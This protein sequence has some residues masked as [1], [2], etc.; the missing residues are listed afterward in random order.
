[1]FS[2][3][4]DKAVRQINVV[5]KFIEHHKSIIDESSTVLDRASI[6]D[7]KIYTASSCVTRLYA[8][9][10]NYVE[11]LISDYLDYTSE[12]VRFRNLP[13]KLKSEYRLGISHILSRSDY[14]RYSHLNYENI[15]SWY[16]EALNNKKN[17]KFVTE[18]LT[19]HEQ[20][21]RLSVIENILQRIQLESIQPWLA[22]NNYIKE[23][24]PSGGSAYEQLNSELNNFI[25]TR[26][27]AAHGVFVNIEGLDILERYCDLIKAL[28]LALSSYLNKTLIENSKNKR[29]TKIGKVT[30]TFPRNSA[31]IVPTKK[32]VSIQKECQL[33]FIGEYFCYSQTLESIQINSENIDGITTISS[34][35][36]IGMKCPTIVQ[37]KSIVYLK[38]N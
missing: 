26:N 24:Y 33:T 21:L 28:S 15:I 31:F 23:L 14:I 2:S 16:N 20:N 5:K 8:I 25:Q 18:A 4:S 38:N 11:S 32:G 27:D 34:S 37:K 17:Y 19:R 3:L 7:Y 30:E 13:E 6:I 36:E 9:F 35:F 22:N 29:F 12:L 10:E 1:M